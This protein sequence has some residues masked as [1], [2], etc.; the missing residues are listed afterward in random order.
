VYIYRLTRLSDQSRRAWILLV[1][2]TAILC[3]LQWLLFPSKYWRVQY[4]AGLLAPTLIFA[5]PFTIRLLMDAWSYLAWDEL[6]IPKRYLKVGVILALLLFSI[7]YYQ[8]AN[9]HSQVLNYAP[10]FTD[11]GEYLVFA[12]NAR[13]LNF[14]YTGD[15]NR[16]PGYPFLQ[17]LLYRPGISDDEF[18]EQG[19]QINILMSIALLG[20]MAWIFRRYLSNFEALLLILMIAFSLY[21][22]KAPYFQ[23]E[24]LFYFLIFVGYLLMQHMLIKPSVRLAIATGVVLGLAHLTKSSV[25]AGLILF[26]GVYAA[27]EMFTGIRQLQHKHLEN[28]TV[29]GISRRLGLL[30]LVFLCFLVVIFPYI[31]A[32][33]I[34]FGSYFYNVNTS[35][36]IWYD[37]NF[38]AIAAEAKYHF[39]EQWPSQLP[40][41]EIPSLRN[42]LRDH[43]L[44]EISERIRFGI[45]AQIDNI[46][47]QFSVTNYH[48]SYLAL[49]ALVILVDLKNSLAMMRKRSFTLL[50]S[51]LYFV[52]YLAA[53]VWYSPISPERR[54]TYGL[55]IP[56]MFSIFIA[57]KE[58]REQQPLG[59]WTSLTEFARASHLVIAM[60]LIINIP[61]VL[62]ERMFFDRYGS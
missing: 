39:A 47:S 12:K 25:I 40:E 48:L 59:G 18:F 51:L 3:S 5:I 30:I 44:P 4:L 9:K 14:N 23:A 52:S 16:M 32:M 35:I 50:F 24:I 21:V 49:L 43:S 33:K 6:Q 45:Q 37:D 27:K 58:L 22:F 11:Q 26:A 54:F 53:F 7:P 38:E 36:Y 46:L 28:F 2:Y 19:K 57:I 41:D 1:V 55:Y 17:A 56:L 29:R 13:L 10:I 31:R 8:A 20:C 15:H 42:Y 62:T 34:R 60:T 61:L